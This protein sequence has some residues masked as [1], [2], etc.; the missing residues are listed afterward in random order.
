M[1][2]DWLVDT[3]LTQQIN[4]FSQV[5]ELIQSGRAKSYQAV[6]VALIETYW[7]VGEN[8]SRKV[9]EASWGKGIVKDLADWLLTQA[10]D[11]KGFSAS[12]LWR[13]KQFYEAYV[14]APKLAA[15]LRVL[16]W[17]KHQLLFQCKTPKEREFYLISATRSHWSPSS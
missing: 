13:M 2:E 17:T 11:L 8:L 15:L 16:S 14:D 12:N 5:L 7:A 10:P 3:H 9:A 6:N 1:P 4:E